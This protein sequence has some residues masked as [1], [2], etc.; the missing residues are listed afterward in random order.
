MEKLLEILSQ[1]MQVEIDGYQFYK[2]ASEKT[3][4]K[5]GKEVF[6]SLAEDEKNHYHILKG[7]YEKVRK[8]GG[9]EFIDKKVEFFKSDSPSPIF[10]EDFRKRIKDMHF[11]MSALSIGAL[12]EKNS[13]EYYR[14]Y[15]EQSEN[16][17]V[18]KLFSYLI[19]WE[20]E[21]LKAL[22]AQQRYLK[23]AYWEDARFFPD[24]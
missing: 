4:D 6:L 13:I 12:L 16:E 2:L 14:K 23:E 5:K 20:Q 10:S 24:I 11:E 8:T 1:A 9:I 22:I 19:E 15:A 21:H 17:E 18:K 7:Q 3:T